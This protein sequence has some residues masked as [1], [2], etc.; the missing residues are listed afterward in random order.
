[1]L[2]GRRARWCL[3]WQGEK[4]AG[5]G[6]QCGSQQLL[7][8]SPEEACQGRVPQSRRKL[9]APHLQPQ[10]FP[11]GSVTSLFQRQTIG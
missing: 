3:V 8:S 6:G 2:A 1:M 7:V 10:L 4:S 5:A 9:G 11:T